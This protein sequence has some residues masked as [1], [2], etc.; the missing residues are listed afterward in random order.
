MMMPSEEIAEVE[1]IQI[2]IN[3]DVFIRN[4]ATFCTDSYDTLI[5]FR[6]SD[7]LKIYFVVCQF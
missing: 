7:F 4:R 2:S 6:N 3:L 5:R 1:T